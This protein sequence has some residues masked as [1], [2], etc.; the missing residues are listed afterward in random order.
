MLGQGYGRVDL[1]RSTL[2]LVTPKEV[3]SKGE[4]NP[5]ESLVSLFFMA[6]VQV[7]IGLGPSVL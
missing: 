5:A 7:S 3:Q 1:S 2:S 4:M 6:L